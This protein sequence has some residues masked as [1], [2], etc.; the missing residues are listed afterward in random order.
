M[1]NNPLYF[2]FVHYIFNPLLNLYSSKGRI[3]ILLLSTFSIFNIPLTTLLRK[4][5]LLI[6]FTSFILEAY[7]ARYQHLKWS[8]LQKYLL[9]TVNYFPKS[10]HLRYLTGLCNTP[11]KSPCVCID[12][13]FKKQMC[14]TLRNLVQFA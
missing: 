14:H 3:F 7:S 5:E 10:L 8:V 13:Y 2:I 4:M 6:H 11:I 9:K 1:N 12:I